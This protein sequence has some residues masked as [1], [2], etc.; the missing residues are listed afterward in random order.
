LPYA[1]FVQIVETI[2][3]ARQ[4]EHEQR[5][6]ELSFVGWQRYLLTPTNDRKGKMAFAQWLDTFGLGRKRPEPA[7]VEGGDALTAEEAIARAERILEMA[8]EE[9]H[10]A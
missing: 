10:G 2:G 1:R 7:P 6:R 8:N 4:D 3:E 5:L 9:R